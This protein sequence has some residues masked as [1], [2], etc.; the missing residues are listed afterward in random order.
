MKLWMTVVE[1]PDNNPNLLT[2]FA[3]RA[4]PLEYHPQYNIPQMSDVRYTM[5]VV[6]SAEVT[7]E[8]NSDWEVVSTVIG[9]S[10]PCKLC[11]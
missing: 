6:D 5:S 10:F 3:N 2:S 9:S 11:K 7:T 1:W 4:T 8:K